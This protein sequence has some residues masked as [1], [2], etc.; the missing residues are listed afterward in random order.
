MNRKIILAIFIIFLSSCRKS[1]EPISVKSQFLLLQDKARYSLY[2][3]NI[4]LLKFTVDSMCSITKVNSKEVV[5]NVVEDEIFKGRAMVW[6]GS[7]CSEVG[8]FLLSLRN[9]LGGL[10]ILRDKNDVEGIC[11]AL[12]EIG[13]T[14]KYL[15]DYEHAKIYLHEAEKL[16][17]DI[18]NNQPHSLSVN[19]PNRIYTRLAEV[20]YAQ[21]LQHR[22]QKNTLDDQT[23]GIDGESLVKPERLRDTAQLYIDKAKNSLPESDKYSMAR[24]LLVQAKTNYHDS[25]NS[26]YIQCVSYSEREGVNLVFIDATISY[27]NYLYEMSS[28]DIV[29]IN[30]ARNY[31]ESGFIMAQKISKDQGILNA[32]RLLGTIYA[33]LGQRS[34][35]KDSIAFFQSESS[36][37]LLLADKMRDSIKDDEKLQKIAAL[38]TTRAIVEGKKERDD[39]KKDEQKKF[40]AYGTLIVFCLICL[41]V[42]IYL[43]K[44]KMKKLD[45]PQKIGILFIILL[46]NCI[47]LY[48][49]PQLERFDENLC[50]L[51]VRILELDDKSS[52]SFDKICSPLLMFMFTA[53]IALGLSWLEEKAREYLNEACGNEDSIVHKAL[54]EPAQKMVD[55]LYSFPLK[56]RDKTAYMLRK[57][58]RRQGRRNK[59]TIQSSQKTNLVQPQELTSFPL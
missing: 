47:H 58:R 9:E 31:A 50:E 10:E 30:Q 20:Y 39:H 4:D 52:V 51:I 44:K 59:I 11:F 34:T 28:S 1:V 14:Y 29:N 15:D 42:F 18:P 19:L 55:G 36:K 6:F 7:Y 56:E 46:A 13:C 57:Q 22:K 5:T 21:Y 35:Y 38:N 49:H 37:K 12:K 41:R 2:N 53:V 33:T 3:G 54:M 26:Y 43:N 17:N 25:A 16:L 32:S 8:D 23:N 40:L 24:T 27:A 48:F 45:R